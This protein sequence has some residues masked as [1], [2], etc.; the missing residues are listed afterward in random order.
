MIFYLFWITGFDRD[1]GLIYLYNN[2]IWFLCC[3]CNGISCCSCWKFI[4]YNCILMKTLS[5]RYTITPIKIPTSH[6]ADT[7]ITNPF[8]LNSYCT[9]CPTSHYADSPIP[10]PFDL[11]SYCTSCPNCLIIGRGLIRSSNMVGLTE[12]C[13]QRFKI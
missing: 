6:Y 9:S 5:I 4:L 2:L 12:N 10:N 3:S 8:D 13:I 11:N 1:Y 7:P